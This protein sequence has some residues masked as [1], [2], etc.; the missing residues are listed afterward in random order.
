VVL[1]L[2]HVLSVLVVLV[3]KHY[4]TENDC[5]LW[6]AANGK[7]FMCADMVFEDCTV[8]WCK[9]DSLRKPWKK[10]LSLTDTCDK[11]S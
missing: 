3:L 9:Y 7:W 8:G 11:N 6:K 4:S 5:H 1:V 10:I 2:I